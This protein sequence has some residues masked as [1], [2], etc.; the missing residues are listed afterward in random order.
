M[1][2]ALINAA[3]RT[4]NSLG[5]TP[6]ALLGLKIDTILL[7]RGVGLKMLKAVKSA[8]AQNPAIVLVS[9]ALG[10]ADLDESLLAHLEVSS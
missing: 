6:A 4:A 2:Q 7:D 8:L 9:V 1:D 10:C 5:C 3:I